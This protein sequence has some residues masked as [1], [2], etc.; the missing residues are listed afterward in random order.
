[1]ARPAVETVAENDDELMELYLEG[2]EPTEEQL[3]AGIRRA[4]LAS[5]VTPVVTGSAFKN[6]GVQP[7]LDAVVA[8]SRRRST[9][10]RSR[11]TRRQEDEIVAREPDEDA[12]LAAL[13]FKIASDPHLGKLT[14]I[15]VYS[16]T[17]DRGSQVLNSTKGNKERI[18][19]IYRMHA[20]KREEIER[21]RR[22][23]RRGDG[24]EEHHDR[25][26]AVRPRP[27]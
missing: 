15:R 4:T 5:K 6:K 9:S 10:A 22:P 8:T 13:A 25:R 11:A 24:S 19:K 12:P 20:N 3:I 1:V 27:R 17:L 7:M 18:G 2:E 21:R 14:Y 26:H 16:G 23:D